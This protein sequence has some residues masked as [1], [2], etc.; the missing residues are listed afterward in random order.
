MDKLANMNVNGN[1]RQA[2]K[3][4]M[5]WIGGTWMDDSALIECLLRYVSVESQSRSLISPNIPSSGH[6]FLRKFGLPLMVPWH[7]QKDIFGLN[8]FLFYSFIFNWRIIA[9]QCRVGFC[10]TST[11]ISQS[12]YIS[13][14]SLEPPSHLPLNLFFIE[15]LL[16]VT[17]N[18]TKT[19]VSG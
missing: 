4:K 3:S 12:L 13:P 9:W 16:A 10:H 17:M 18:M 19:N 2:G 11:W 8:L 15:V 5:F 1:I 14:F 7:L 6:F